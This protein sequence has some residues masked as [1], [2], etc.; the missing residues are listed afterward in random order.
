M[1]QSTLVL[2]VATSLLAAA[3][4]IAGT[5]VKGNI[6]A[7]TAGTDPQL[8]NKSKFKIDGTGAYKVTV[9]GMTDSG[10][11]LVPVSSGTTPDTQYWLVIKGGGPGLV[12]EYNTPFNPS[13]EGQA[14]ISGSL[15]GLVALLP[16]GTSVGVFGIEIHEPTPAG[17]ETT[18]CTE[19]M[20]VP[21]IADPEILQIY[22]EGISAYASNPCAAGALVGMSGISTV[23][24][25]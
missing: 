14:T 10:G 24:A 17:Q 18:D 3:P 1:K 2:A 25:P 4:A 21:L 16:A 20:T 7:A 22:I 6:V 11:N 19:V 5:S 12:F 15:A 23:P 13:K 8:L 9:K